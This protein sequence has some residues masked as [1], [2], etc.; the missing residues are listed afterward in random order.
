MLNDSDKWEVFD[1]F[2]TTWK[3]CGA[4]YQ[5]LHLISAGWKLVQVMAM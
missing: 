4:E 1:T 2:F 5:N 3:V